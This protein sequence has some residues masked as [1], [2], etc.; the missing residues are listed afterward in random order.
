MDERA[1]GDAFS[2]LAPVAAVL[3]EAFKEILVLLLTPAAPHAVPYVLGDC[4]LQNPCPQV[5]V[6]PTVIK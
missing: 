6:R 4:A 1:Q 5:E 3:R 2:D